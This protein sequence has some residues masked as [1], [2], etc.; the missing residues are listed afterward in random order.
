MESKT[1]LPSPP[2]SVSPRPG[3]VRAHP[4]SYMRPHSPPIVDS[5]KN[6]IEPPY[7]TVHP[8]DSVPPF[9]GP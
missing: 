4:L 3:K 7:S 6:G 5:T 1:S 2:S 9:L 8:V